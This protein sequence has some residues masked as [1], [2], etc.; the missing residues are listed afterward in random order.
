MEKTHGKN[1]LQENIFNSKSTYINITH[2]KELMPHQPTSQKGET[3]S[4]DLLQAAMKNLINSQQ[5]RRTK[6][7]FLNPLL[8]ELTQMTIQQCK[9]K[10]IEEAHKRL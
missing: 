3:T 7:K 4:T 2:P 10:P 5:F 6:K 1:V 8:S 9:I